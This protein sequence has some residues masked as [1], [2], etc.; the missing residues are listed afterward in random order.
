MGGCCTKAKTNRQMEK[1]NIGEW[2]EDLADKEAENKN[3]IFSSGGEYSDGADQE[4]AQRVKDRS[5]AYGG[6]VSIEKG[7]VKDD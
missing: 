4:A 7:G 1:R 6:T 5:L 3:D 2:T